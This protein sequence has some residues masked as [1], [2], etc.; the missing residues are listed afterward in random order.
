MVVWTVRVA[1]AIGGTL[2]A[3]AEEAAGVF[4]AVEVTDTLHFV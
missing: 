2:G 4:A 1:T 3:G